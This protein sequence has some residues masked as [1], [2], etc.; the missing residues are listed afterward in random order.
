MSA[1]RFRKVPVVIEAWWWDGSFEE[2]ERIAEWMGVPGGFGGVGGTTGELRIDTLEGT[3]H[4]SSGDY[5]IRG[6]KGEFYPCKRNIF[7]ATYVHDGESN[8]TAPSGPPPSR[9]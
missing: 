1:Q 9:P 4:V 2:A 6:V 5:V 7:K 8:L 3:M